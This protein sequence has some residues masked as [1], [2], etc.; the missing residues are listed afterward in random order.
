M[1]AALKEYEKQFGE[2]CE[3]LEEMSEMQKMNTEEIREFQ[4]TIERLNYE[5]SELKDTLS[6]ERKT[7]N[8]D[9]SFFM[10]NVINALSISLIIIINKKLQIKIILT[11]YII[12]MKLV[13]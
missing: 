13:P 7:N 12:R 5:K 6:K 11:I 2:M 1:R 4:K 9:V 10:E 3:A 8:V